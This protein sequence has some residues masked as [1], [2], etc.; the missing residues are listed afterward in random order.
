MLV[1][2]VETSTYAE[3]VAL[4]DGEAVL[5][6]LF[7]NSGGGNSE[8]IVLMTDA[9]VRQVGIGRGELQGVAVSAGPG[10]FTPLRIGMAA[11]KGFALALGIP[12]IGVSSL[13]ALAAGAAF[14]P[15]RICSIIDA[16]RGEVF[17]ALFKFTEGGVVERLS[18]D[19]L[20][21][22]DAL[23][24][25]VSDKTLFI[26]SGALV[27]RDYL[28]QSLGGFACFAEP[29]MNFPRASS[30]ALLGARRL[31]A[32]ASDDVMSLAPRYLK[33]TDAEISKG[34]YIA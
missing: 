31:V 8:S 21:T 15:W 33:R 34:R 16:K 4:V 23:C 28:S 14:V 12:I 18:D 17:A 26:G 27:H 9:L 24:G 5:G 20:T 6:E 25:G 10:A 3:S 32:G 1:L 7:V 11:A 30:A 29:N 13:V 2:G 19:E 22:P